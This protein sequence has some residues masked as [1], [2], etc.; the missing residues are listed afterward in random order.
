MLCLQK[1]K[2]K[3]N[4]CSHLKEGTMHLIQSPCKFLTQQMNWVYPRS[5]G[6]TPGQYPESLIAPQGPQVLKMAPSALPRK[7]N[8]H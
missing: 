6:K 2:E 4:L 8:T 1:K 3:G 7:R 5:P